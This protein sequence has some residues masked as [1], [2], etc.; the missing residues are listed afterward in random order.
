M[1]PI[2]DYPKRQFEVRCI[3]S[4]LMYKTYCFKNA[5]MREIIWRNLKCV[6]NKNLIDVTES[7][8]PG[9]IKISFQK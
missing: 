4:Q 6:F 7:S 3:Q 8:Y 9:K 1:T 2:T 5:F